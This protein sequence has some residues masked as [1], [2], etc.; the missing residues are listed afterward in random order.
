MT[1]SVCSRRHVLAT[2]GA[3]ASTY[4]LGSAGQPGLLRSYPEGDIYAFRWLLLRQILEKSAWRDAEIHGLG[5]SE[6]VQGRAE[7]L[8]QSGEI[9]V[10]CFGISELRLQKLKPI[11]IDI[12]RG[13]VGLRYFVVRDSDRQRIAALSDGDFLHTLRFGLQ[14]QWADVPVMRAN[15]LTL[16]LSAKS[17]HLY[18]M[19]VGGRCDA[20]PRGANEILIEIASNRSNAMPVSI[21]ASRALYFP[22]PI[23]YWVRADDVPLAN[24]IKSGLQRLIG[25]GRFDML[26]RKH[27]ARELAFIRE[28]RRRIIRLSAEALPQPLEEPDTRIWWPRH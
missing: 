3:F 21:E 18:A 1:R 17:D 9:D 28:S 19:L 24:A 2:A 15:G 12:M 6:A 22:Y 27:H 20:L 13:L 8:L 4:A 16:E 26:F 14:A 23:Y 5:D 11:R 25:N 7:I 10:A